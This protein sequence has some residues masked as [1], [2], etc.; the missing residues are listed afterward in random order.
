MDER[1]IPWIDRL[2]RG[3]YVRA[4]SLTGEYKVEIDEGDRQMLCLALA[5]LAA[6]RPGWLDALRRIAAKLPDGRRMFD[7]FWELERGARG[8]VS[9]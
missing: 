6:R 4:P 2:R 9:R 3:W 7:D 8:W 5:D 1:Q